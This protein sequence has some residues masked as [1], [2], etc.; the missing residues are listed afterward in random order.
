MAT[1]KNF[2]DELCNTAEI[3][4][5]TLYNPDL[6][7][8]FKISPSKKTFLHDHERQESGRLMRINHVGEICAQALYSGQALTTQ[9]PKLKASLLEKA[10]EEQA[11][12]NWC[13]HRL[14]TLKTPASKLNIFWYSGSFFLGLCAGLSG[15]KVGLGFIE[16]TE[17]QVEVHLANQ[18]TR[19]PPTD[20]LSRAIVEQMRQDEQEHAQWANS[21]GASALPQL[22]KQA[23]SF[24][25]TLMKRIAYWI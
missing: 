9:C 22:V 3:A 5:H 24:T 7:Q 23:M 2:L 16:E 21:N 14:N 1:K 19:L 13:K 25:A 20:H 6:S 15:K 4:L 12:L 11:H 8:P 17:N 18:L 10:T